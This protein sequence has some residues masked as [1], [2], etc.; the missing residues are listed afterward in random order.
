MNPN[1]SR[2]NYT[3]DPNHTRVPFKLGPGANNNL[4]KIGTTAANQVDITGNLVVSGTIT[5]DFVFNADFELESIEEHSE[6]MWRE[7]HLP[8]VSPAT[9]AEDGKSHQINVGER[10]EGLLKELEKAHIYIAQLNSTIVELRSELVRRN[11]EFERRLSE[12]EAL[13]AQQAQESRSAP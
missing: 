5:P 13:P 4:L 6:F 3:D 10:S 11:E 2:L 9:L 1:T 7:K 12:L 8:A